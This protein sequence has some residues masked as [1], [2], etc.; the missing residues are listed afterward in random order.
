LVWE[1]DSGGGTLVNGT[2]GVGTYSAP[3]SA[4][5]LSISQK[6]QS[7]PSKNK[8]R[9]SSKTI[10]APSGAYMVREPGS[11]LK[12]TQNTWSIGFRGEIFLL[13]KNVSFAKL[14][15]SEGAT[16]ATA[17]GWLSS[18]NGAPHNEGAWRPIGA[19]DANTGCYV[20]SIDTVENAT[21]GPPYGVGTFNWPIP[22][23]YR[24]AGTTSSGTIFYTAN[25]YATADNIGTATIQKAGAGPFSRVPSDPTSTY[26]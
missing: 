23:R 19:C 12:H 26:Y 2:N 25:H 3:D 10:V 6:V 13:P 4:A 9:T 20:F 24:K 11:G 15:F 8:K 1:I 18:A 5:T 7:G 14:Q 21:I 17:T 16:V 22:W